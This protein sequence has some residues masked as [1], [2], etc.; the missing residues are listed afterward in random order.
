MSGYH[1][2]GFTLAELLITLAILGIIAAF[3]IPKVLESQRNEKYNA[4]L[5]ET[6]ATV[7]QAWLLHKN[8]NLLNA[9]TAA[10]DFA[11]YMNYINLDTTS[12]LDNAPYDPAGRKQCDSTNPCVTFANGAKI[13]LENTSA[14]GGT[15]NLHFIWIL[16]D[17]DGQATG[18]SDSVWLGLY[19][20]GR[21]TLDEFL[22][23]GSN[24]HGII[25][26]TSPAC[27]NCTPDW[28]QF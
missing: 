15:S 25:I 12:E 23:V 21:I 11:Q 9:N 18:R 4:I 16:F 3:T 6:M 1:R 26:S 24:T 17:P 28:I 22:S 14:F 20:N 8:A 19:Y 10:P 7:S 27:T 2:K 5:K 13:W